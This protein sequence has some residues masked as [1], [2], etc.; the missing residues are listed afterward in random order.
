MCSPV[1]SVPSIRTGRIAAMS[2]LAE[3][4]ELREQL[5]QI[6]IDAV[7]PVDEDTVA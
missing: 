1:H 3:D 5:V 6:L 7:R 4:Y 2:F